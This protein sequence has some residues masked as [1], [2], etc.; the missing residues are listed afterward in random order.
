MFE[1]IKHK[2]QQRF[3]DLLQGELLKVQLEKNQLFDAYLAALPED[4]RQ[5]HNCNCCK[6]FL[7][8]YGSLIAIK[9]GEVQTLWDFEVEAPYNDVPAALAAIVKE[10]ANIG[11]FVSSFAKL[12]TDSNIQLLENGDT[13][14][15]Q[16]FYVELPKDR[17]YRSK[18][19]IDTEIGKI[20]TNVQVFER[21]LKELSV[22]ATQTV[23]ELIGQNSLYRGAEFRSMLEKFLQHQRTIAGK[24]IRLYAWEHSKEAM[25]IR[26]SAIGTLL[27][28]LSEGKE[29]DVAVRAYEQK[30]APQNYRRPTA[31]VTKA[32]LEKAEKELSELGLTESLLR[33]HA[34]KDDIPVSE[35]LFVNRPVAVEGSVFDVLKNDVSTDPR[36]FSRVEVVPFD[37]FIKEVL[38]VANSVE[39]LFE[40][41]HI[42]NLMNLTAAKN[43]DAAGLF[44]WSNDVA[45]VYKDG[46]ADSVKERVKN[47]GGSVDGFL[48]ISLEWYNTDDLD[49]HVIQPDKTKIYYGNKRIGKG[50][51][52]VDMNISGDRRDAVENVIYKTEP[53][54]GIYTVVINNFTRRENIDTGFGVEIEYN[55]EVVNLSSQKSPGNK[56]N[57]EA[58]K[59]E[60]RRATGFKVIS[61]LGS[62]APASKEAY[63]LKTNQFY[64][65]SAILPSPNYWGGSKIGNLHT[66]FLFD[67]ARSDVAIRGFFNEFLK[68][69]LRD[70]RKVF[71][72]L[73]ERIKVQ[74]D[75]NQLSGLGFSSTQPAEVICRVTGN[76][77]RVIKVKF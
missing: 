33:R 5:E 29:L 41:K 20:N 14:R 64:K 22:D 1:T 36:S 19:T 13:I 10:N 11:A 65:A 56:G 18:A 27:V 25:N 7:N 21:A 74:P 28:D 55:G 49:L 6:S 17:V 73:A 66:F 15:W 47:A 61:S 44:S 30:V 12:G 51:L 60:Y 32:M 59:I 39:V 45:W 52:D 63:G 53:N 71:E 16:H 54:E 3:Q 4:L 72:L 58:A 26:N 37:K 57:I 35:M 24:D 68:P 42:G 76:F 50:F 2:V 43:P 46:V 8:H 62:S 23:L 67:E 40:N 70:H 34:T 75:G 38:P 69:E 9:D 77:T 48:R 31:L